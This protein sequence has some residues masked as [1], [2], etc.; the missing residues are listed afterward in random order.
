MTR[1]LR[2]LLVRVAT[3]WSRARVDRDIAAELESHLQLHIDDNLRAGLA[4]DEARRRAVLAL[5][6]VEATR[7]RC[8]DQRGLPLIDGLGQDVV[9]AV[10]ALRTHPGFSVVAILTLALGIGANSAIFSVVNAVLLRPLP[11]ADPSRLVMVFATDAARGDQYDVASYPAFLDWQEQN[12]SFASMAAFTNRQLIVGVGG[13]FVYARGKAIT[14]NLFDLL[15][16]APALG[17]SFRDFRPGAPDVV[18]LSHA[19]WARSF[20]ARPEAV[21]ETIRIDDRVRTIVGVMPPGFHVEGDYERYYEPLA[22]DSSRGHGFLHVAARLRPG[23]SVAQARD[24]M[25]AIA[26]R[27]AHAYPRQHTGVG[28]HVVPMSTALAKNVRF[29]LLVMLGVVA[30]VLFIACANVAGLM[31]ARGAARHRELA[32]RAALGAG[33]W[34]I[35]RQL[36]TESAVLALAGGALGLV[37]A[38][39]TTRAL[40]SALSDQYVVPR[41]AETRTDVSVLAFTLAI[42]IATGLAFGA[43]PAIAAW[44]PD[45]NDALRDGARGASGVRAPR[46]RRGLIVLETALALVLLAGAGTLLK[47]LLTLRAT[48]PGFDTTDVLKADL[49]LPLPKYAAFGDRARFYESAQQ[50]VRALP[51]VRSAAFVS[52][53]P[54]NGSSDSL[55]FHIVG[56]PDPAAGKPFRC[57]FNMATAGYFATLG[58]PIEAGREFD[59]SDRAA[60][61]PVVIVNA[62]AARTYWPGESPLGRQIALPGPRG[63]SQTLTV[64][65]VAGDVHHAGL[66]IP[67]RPEMYLATLQAPLDWPW[68]SIVVRTHGD[69]ARLADSLKAALASIDATVAVQRIDTLAAVVALSMIEPRVYTL[70]LGAFAALAVLLAAIGLYGLMAYSVSQRRHELGI[71]LAL[72]ATRVEVMRLVVREGAWL[73]AA[74]ALVGLAGAAAATRLIASLVKGAQPNDPATLAAVTMVLLAAALTASYLPARRAAR[75]DPIAALRI[76]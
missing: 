35:A 68:S 56:R 48:P 38:G 15:G 25:N 72:G 75:V 5:G 76:D 46:L 37:A 62:T 4:P 32:V 67:P 40:V 26:D 65:G 70:L 3:L 50:R 58:I 19:F 36:L 6:G 63:S 42:S 71:R 64:V 43:G 44:S 30:L 60:T 11:F 17:R 47:T 66:G 34:R 9:L 22:A 31:L 13:D 41:L 54:L 55:G 33:R 10:R 2:S 14:P 59:D 74:G 52:D 39:W 61:L 20:G 73:V 29:G 8:R 53:L 18:V 23:V 21:G 45:L 7:E 28:A 24:D 1:R 27:L 51:G 12:R 49:L 16:V 69:P 57:G